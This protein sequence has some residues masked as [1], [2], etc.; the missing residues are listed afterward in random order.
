MRANC[1]T[2]V[3]FTCFL[4]RIYLFK[5][6]SSNHWMQAD[7][8]NFVVHNSYRTKVVE[9]IVPVSLM[10]QPSIMK[11]CLQVINMSHTFSTKSTSFSHSSAAHLISLPR[12]NTKIY[13][14][15]SS[16]AERITILPYLFKITTQTL[17]TYN[18]N[19]TA[20]FTQTNIFDY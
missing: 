12:K 3:T 17:Y 9:V 14:N 11:R 10:T 15:T 2:Y 13:N 1:R 8:T 18:T 19:Q 20:I 7:Y 16:S 5:C 6:A 4:C